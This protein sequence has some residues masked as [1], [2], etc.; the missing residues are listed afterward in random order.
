M[1]AQKNISLIR[2][3]IEEQANKD[4]T[5]RYEE[6]I[7]PDV[8]IHGPAS[9]QKIRGIK[10]TQKI[11]VSYIQAYPEKKFTIEEIFCRADKVFVRWICK[12]RHKGKVKGIYPKKREFTIA[13]FSIYRVRKGKI[14]E[15]WQFWDRLGLLE[16]IGEISVHTDP[17]EPGY[18][19][20]LLKS[21]GMEHYLEQVHLLSQRERECLRCLL[22]GKTAKETAAIFHLSPR[23]V[24]SHFEKIKRKLKSSSKRD[25]FDA[26]K[27]L[28]KLELL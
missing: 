23:T 12:G 16:Q 24:E 26:A 18:Y 7:S 2:E 21:L 19:F 22:E 17:V 3:F 8:L 10:A 14:V 1:H 28:E 15:I 11:D 5:S 20:N 6:F 13:G 9:G 25:L 4:D 27:I